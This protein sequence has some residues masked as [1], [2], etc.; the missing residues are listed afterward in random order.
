MPPA[1]PAPPC[2]AFVGKSG[3]G[4]TTLVA[5]VVAELHR[6]GL[7]VGAVKHSHGF[8]DPD[9][10]GKDSQRLRAAGAERLLLGS[11]D[12]TVVFWRHEGHEPDFEARLRLLGDGLDVVLVESYSSHALPT[13]EVLRRGHCETLRF[14]GDPRLEAVAADFEPAGLAVPRLPL[15]DP[16]GVA[17]FVLQLLSGAGSRSG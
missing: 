9:A 13:I 4:K 16:A 15:D 2:V 10:E 5:G 17:Q 7:R 1:K 3:V 12:A 8:A 14:A 11:G 6:A